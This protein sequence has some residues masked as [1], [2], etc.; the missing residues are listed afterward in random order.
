MQRKLDTRAA[1][2]EK[3]DEES[4][5]AAQEAGRAMVTASGQEGWERAVAYVLQEEP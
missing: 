5:K 1:L 4:W 2:R 3:L